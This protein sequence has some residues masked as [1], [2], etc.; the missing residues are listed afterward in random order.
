MPF[1]FFSVGETNASYTFDFGDKSFV[2]TTC[3]N[4]THKYTR[5]G[6]FEV[7][8]SARNSQ[9]GPIRA[10]G[11]VS[12][13]SSLGIV[14]IKCPEEIV[15]TGNVTKITAYTTQ[16][17]HLT[18]KWITNDQQKSAEFFNISGKMKA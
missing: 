11:W 1:A 4:T 17:T 8:V 15:E 13:E 12:I 7:K 3:C 6:V 16:G 10:S 2:L 18:A 14:R 9:S 5:T